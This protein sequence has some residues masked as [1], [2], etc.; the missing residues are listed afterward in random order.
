MGLF[1][2]TTPDDGRR[3]KAKEIVSGGGYPPKEMVHNWYTQ[4]VLEG[5]TVTIV[6]K[7]NNIY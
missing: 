2:T 6:L 7:I 1:S 3:P 4:V 5:C